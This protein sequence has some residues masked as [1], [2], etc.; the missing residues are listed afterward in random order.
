[1]AALDEAC[2]FVSTSGETH[3]KFVDITEYLLLSIGTGFERNSIS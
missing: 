3:L 1:M 2:V